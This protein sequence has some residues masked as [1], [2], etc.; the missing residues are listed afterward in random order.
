MHSNVKGYFERKIA[1]IQLIKP[2][3]LRVE[4]LQEGNF[5]FLST[6]R[7]TAP[8]IPVEV[9]LIFDDDMSRKHSD[10]KLFSFFWSFIVFTLI[11]LIQLIEHLYNIF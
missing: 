10:F 1:V 8:W 2:A 5:T 11:K 4:R 7:Q 6:F 3:F 9:V